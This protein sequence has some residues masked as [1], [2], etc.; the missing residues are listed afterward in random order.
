LTVPPPDVI[1]VSLIGP[2]YGESIIV[3]LG[4]GEWMIVDSCIQRLDEGGSQSAAVAYLREIGVDPSQVSRV[5]ATHWHDDHIGGLSQVIDECA[6]AVFCCAMALREKEFIGFAAVYAEADP[7]PIVRST[8]EIMDVLGLLE[9]RGKVP[10]FLVRD[11]LVRRTNRNVSVYA[12]S[13]SSERIRDFLARLAASMPALKTTRTRMGD[14]SPNAIAVALFIDLGTDAILLGADVE[15]T[16]GGAW[17]TIIVT[18]EAMRGHRSSM[19]KVAHHGSETAECAAI[20]DTLPFPKPFAILTPNTHLS[21]PLPSAEAV[22]RILE[23]T[24]HAYSTARL[25]STA[26]R[27]RDIAV[28]RT[29]R[30]NGWRIRAVEPKAG[31][32]R[33]R[34]RLGDP[35]GD[36]CVEL[37]RN[38]T[39]LKHIRS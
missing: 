4:D 11:T 28:E 27:R 1:E 15:E 33:L 13:P 22:E 3:H 38:A 26:P 34:R 19:Y 14:M 7:S 18:S 35:T 6:S 9:S 12:L 20:W 21:R 32:V 17:S 29:L 39:H 25:T 37:R 23:R 24:P 31:H 2:G 16:P 10:I 5:I 8:R 30:E 36:W